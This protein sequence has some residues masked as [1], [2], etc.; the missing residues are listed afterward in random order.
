VFPNSIGTVE[1]NALTCH[2]DSSVCCRGIDNPGSTN[3][4]GDWVDVTGG[5]VSKDSV[6]GDGFYWVRGFG[7]VRLHRQGVDQSGQLGSYCCRIPDNKSTVT[8]FCVNLVGKYIHI[9]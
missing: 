9:L 3:G 5:Q 2:T 4:L 8:T 1:E 7:N 6:D